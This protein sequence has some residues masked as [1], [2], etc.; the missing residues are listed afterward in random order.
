MKEKL[1]AFTFD[2]GPVE[3]SED[4]SAMSILHTLE[5]YGQ[6]ATFFYVGQQINQEN[7]KEMEFARS[8][9]CEAANHTF[10]HC[11]LTEHTEE[12]IK[13]E[14]EKTERLIE[15]TLG[16]APGLVRPPYLAQN[17]TV[18][19]AVAYP[20]ISCSVDS[21]D[22]DHVSTEV[23]I[24]RIMDADQKGELENAVVLL[25]ETYQTTARAVETLIPALLEKGY[26]FVTVSELAEQNG[27][28]LEKHQLYHRIGLPD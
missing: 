5:K 7:K 23:I 26:R 15:E 16:K 8:I 27:I 24:E 14:I 1:V 11:F 28:T 13:E 9:G 10:T 20:M 18:L 25:H 12:E 3:Y 21:R 2:D 17:E 6:Q 4:S 19:N 22:W